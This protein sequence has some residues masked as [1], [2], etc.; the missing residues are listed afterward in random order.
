MTVTK[1]EYMTLCPDSDEGYRVLLQEVGEEGWEAVCT[2]CE[3]TRLEAFAGYGGG[4]N[5]VN[6]ILFK[7]PVE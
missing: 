4:F 3:R 1:W 7:R 6:H 5:Y 2:W